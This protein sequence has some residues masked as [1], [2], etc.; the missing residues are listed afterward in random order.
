MDKPWYKQKTL[1]AGGSL[2]VAGVGMIVA[3]GNYTA[4]VLGI[5]NG[6][7]LIFLRQAIANAANKTE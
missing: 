1:Y 3:E 6:L 2:I 4:G 5:L 7:G